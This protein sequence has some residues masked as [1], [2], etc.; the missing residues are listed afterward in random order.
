MASPDGQRIFRAER[1]G[2][3]SLGPSG[4]GLGVEVEVVWRLE[5]KVVEGGK[6]VG[7]R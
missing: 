6:V 1:T 7:W 2:K 5:V 3:V 4:G